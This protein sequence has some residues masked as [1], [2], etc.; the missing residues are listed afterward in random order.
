MRHLTSLSQKP[1]LSSLSFALILL[2]NLWGSLEASSLPG[3]PEPHSGPSIQPT[4][5]SSS[6]QRREEEQEGPLSESSDEKSGALGQAAASSSGV[7]SSSAIQENKERFDPEECWREM[8]SLAQ[9]RADYY[10]G[11]YQALLSTDS[12]LK[13]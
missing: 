5:S 6:P 4:S 11:I 13:E 1:F 3:E 12:T 9:A 10:Q 8:L 2:S 7:P